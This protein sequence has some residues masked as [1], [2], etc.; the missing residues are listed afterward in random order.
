MLPALV[1]TLLTVEP[2]AELLQRIVERGRTIEAF[3]GDARVVV[4]VRADEL[5][6]DGKVVS[7]DL[8]RFRL[9]K[10]G[11]E[12]V[13]TELLLKSKDGKDV[14][15]EAKAE[16]QKKDEGE[17]KS[18]GFSARSPFHPDQLAKYR[19]ALLA[20]PKDEPGL[21]RIGFQ[22][23]GEKTPELVMGEATVDPATGELL[24]STMRPSKNPRFVDHLVMDLEYGA[25]TP[26][27]RVL[28]R[29]TARGDGGFLFIRK[30]FAVVTTFSEW[31]AVAR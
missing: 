5:D 13:G 12:T 10:K 22:P 29:L 9:V 27:G 25:V 14:T 19:F 16:Q 28:S 7:T 15:A 18:V 23:A 3:T 1:L 26:A 20:P 17:K 2:D 11:G 31:E 6:G 30:R 24:A 21:V 8:S 4:E